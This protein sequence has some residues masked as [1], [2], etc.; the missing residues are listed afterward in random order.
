MPNLLLSKCKTSVLIKTLLAPLSEL[1]T[2]LPRLLSDLSIARGQIVV[3][4]LRSTIDDGLHENVLLL[5]ALDANDSSPPVIAGLIAIVSADSATL[6]HASF[7]DKELRKAQ[8]LDLIDAL[9]VSLDEI[10]N[11]RKVPYVQWAR[12][13]EEISELQSRW[14][15]RLR[16][17]W[18]ADLQYMTVSLPIQ[19]DAALAISSPLPSSPSSQI[20][21]SQITLSPIDWEEPGSLENFTST[22]EKTYVDSLDCPAILQY[23][24]AAQTVAGYQLPASFRPSLWFVVKGPFNN[25]DLGAVILAQHSSEVFELVYMA[26]VP[27]ARGRRLGREIMKSVVELISEAGGQRLILAVD[28][29]NDPAISLYEQFGMQRMLE[30]SVWVKALETSP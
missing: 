20:A 3:D 12:D 25:D 11:T 30:E 27:E 4:Q 8:Q 1:T 17:T 7:L 13:V 5:T 16:F 14:F 9:R 23:R 22:I 6:L 2:L 28:Q 21:L 26:L 15:E 19:S 10:L 29:N 24:S 18:V